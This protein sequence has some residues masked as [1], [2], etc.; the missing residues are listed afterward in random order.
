[1]GYTSM[2]TRGRAADDEGRD[3]DQHTRMC[4]SLAR[5]PQLPSSFAPTMSYASKAFV[6]KPAPSFEADALLPSGEFGTLKLEQYAAAGKY[7]PSCAPTEAQSTRAQE[8][9]R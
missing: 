2:C 7:G 8:D 3:T 1:V 9:R 6:T 5:L 4:R